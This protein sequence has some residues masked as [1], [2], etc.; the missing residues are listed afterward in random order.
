VGGALKSKK[1][2]YIGLQFWC[3]FVRFVGLCGFVLEG[4]FW[5]GCGGVGVCGCGVVGGVVCWWDEGGG[6]GELGLRG[7]FGGWSGVNLSWGGLVWGGWWVG[8]V[9]G[10]VVLM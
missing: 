2:G 6:V 9:V 3:F 8:L 7:C 10:F 1:G 4:C 5:L